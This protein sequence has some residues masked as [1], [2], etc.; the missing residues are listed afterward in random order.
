M[1]KEKG[2]GLRRLSLLV[3]L[4]PLLFA[5]PLPAEDDLSPTDVSRLIAANF[6]VRGGDALGSATLFEAKE[7]WVLTN[8]HCI[9][10][11]VRLVERDEVQADGTVKRVK[12][13]FYEDITLSQTAYGA[14]SRVGE[15]ALRARVLA[16]SPDKDLAVL[17]I[18]SETTPL[19]A[20]AR[21]PPDTHRLHQGQTVYAVGNPV[22]LENTITRGLLNHLYREH[23]WDA[24]RVA[25]YIQTDATIAGGSSGGA[26]YDREGWLIGVPAAGFRGVALNFAIPFPVYKTFLR[27]HGFARAWDPTA[28]TR[29]EWLADQAS[30]KTGKPEEV[31][32]P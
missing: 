2:L 13:A 6:V 9:E 26:L 27:D 19:V 30:R 12:R 3:P 29:A 1:W 8:H 32:K 21:I 5:S 17:Q 31:K 28:P 11:V 22:G 24:D 16:F 14:E 18:L 23:R 20:A 10:G 7:R 15:L 25:R 4:L